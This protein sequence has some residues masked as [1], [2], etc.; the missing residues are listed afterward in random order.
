MDARCS[1]ALFLD[2]TLDIVIRAG[3]V[4][5]LELL[6]WQGLCRRFCRFNVS[7]NLSDWLACKTFGVPTSTYIPA[8]WTLCS[9]L[10]EGSFS[11]VLKAR[12]LNLDAYCAV[13]ITDTQSYL[14]KAALRSTMLRPELESSFLIALC[15]ENIVKVHGVLT[16]T[17]GVIMMLEYFELGDVLTDV[18]RTGGY[19][20]DRTVDFGFQIGSA[21][22]F[23][24][25]N[26]IIH[27]DVKPENVLVSLTVN[28]VV[29]FVLTDFG[30]AR[31]C[32]SADACLT[33][34][35]TQ[36]YMAPE[37]FRM[38]RGYVAG[39]CSKAD[40]WSLGVTMY[41]C[42]TNELPFSFSCSPADG[43]TCSLSEVRQGI[44]EA[45]CILKLMV[46]T[47]L[48]L[49]PAARKEMTSAHTEWMHRRSFECDEISVMRCIG[50][51]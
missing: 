35:G 12:N 32:S 9:I 46:M 13:K 39:Y 44:K 50:Q 20:T 26:S 23:L 28:N 27:R 11:V 48:V 43:G 36:A 6:R 18:K 17:R 1:S 30:L 25:S 33:F 21:L 16:T 42:F 10:G 24:H 15:H 22:S 29:K 19:G 7:G 2:V 14:V 34:V 31:T 4:D 5:L 37:I 3:F 38:Q 49:D 45:S 8:E 41:A 40:V 47:C 51:S